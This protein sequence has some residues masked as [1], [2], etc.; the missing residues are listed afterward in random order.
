MEIELELNM[1]M[2]RRQRMMGTLV[3]VGKMGKM[4]NED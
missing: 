2:K 1:K 4:G 3:R